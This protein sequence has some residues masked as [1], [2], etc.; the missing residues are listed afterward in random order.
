MPPSLRAYGLLLIV[1][2]TASSALSAQGYLGSR[3]SGAPA[4]SRQRRE[5]SDPHHA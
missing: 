5:P 4:R 1:V 3:R 2:L